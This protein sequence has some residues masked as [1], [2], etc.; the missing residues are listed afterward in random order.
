VRDGHP[1]AGPACSFFPL[2]WTPSLLHAPTGPGAHDDFLLCI[3]H[4]DKT[5]GVLLWEG[6]PRGAHQILH[7]FFFSQRKT[8]G[9]RQAPAFPTTAALA[10][11]LTRA[12]AGQAW[13]RIGPAHASFSFPHNAK[14]PAQARPAGQPRRASSRLVAIFGESRLAWG[15]GEAR[16][17]HQPARRAGAIAGFGV[18]GF[19]VDHHR[20]RD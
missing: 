9:R 18:G 7:F 12:R 16:L 11:S 13:P 1:S 15:G 20:G 14:P 10:R 17:G 8:P 4:I 19:S 2:S 6:V 5:G 3:H